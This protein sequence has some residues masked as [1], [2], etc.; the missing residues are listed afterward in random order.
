MNHDLQVDYDHNFFLGFLPIFFRRWRV[1]YL[2]VRHFK[3]V[4]IVSVRSTKRFVITAFA[5]H[6][7]INVLYNT[8]PGAPSHGDQDTSVS[9]VD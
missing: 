9:I 4:S 8:A 1:S 5:I 7:Y 3:L 6:F 2:R